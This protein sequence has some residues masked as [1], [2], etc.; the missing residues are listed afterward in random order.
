MLYLCGTSDGLD[1]CSGEAVNNCDAFTGGGQALPLDPGTPRRGLCIDP[2]KAFWIANTG[3]TTV[4]IY[5]TCQYDQTNPQTIPLTIPPY[6]RVYIGS[7]GEC[8]IAECE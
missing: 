6:S 2:G 7:N 5:V 3:G 4:N 1:N 8:V